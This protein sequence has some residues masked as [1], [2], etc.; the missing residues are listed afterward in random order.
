M[1]IK[2]TIIYRKNIDENVI[3]LEFVIFDGD[4]PVHSVEILYSKNGKGIW[5]SRRLLLSNSSE[6]EV[7]N[8]IN[9]CLLEYYMA[10][11]EKL[12]EIHHIE[13]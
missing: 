8:I 7:Q 6:Q 4:Y 1:K 13:K 12:S 11:A 10:D 3:E 2:S 5:S 9:E